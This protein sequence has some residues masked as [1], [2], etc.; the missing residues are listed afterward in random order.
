VVM[1]VL[2]LLV[3]ILVML[4]RC[5]VVLFMI[6]MLKCCWFRVVAVGLVVWVGVGMGG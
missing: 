3:C 5:S 4:L 1:R 2:F 6:C